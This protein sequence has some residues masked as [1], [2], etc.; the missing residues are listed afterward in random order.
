MVPVVVFGQMDPTQNQN[1]SPMNPQSP[2]NANVPLNQPGNPTQT[3]SQATPQNSMRD[4]LGA[5]G[6]TGQRMQDKRF[7]RSAAEAGV[8]DV[9]LAELAVQKSSSPAV[10]E[11]AQR[12][13]DDHT[14]INNDIADVADNVGV[15][16]PRKMSKRDQA[17]YEKLNGLSG[18]D[19]DT[20]Y[21]TYIAKEHWQ[22]LHTFHQEA[23]AA[24]MPGLEPEIVKA[25]HTMHEHLKLISETASQ[26]GITLPPRPQRP[27]KQMPAT[28]QQ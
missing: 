10:K 25:L 16:L 28:T 15:P 23:S 12:M 26:E 27:P 13:I 21:V 22:D 18:K 17:E 2:Q 20:E 7:I 1:P 24:E 5:P 14:A 8:G 9:K 4:S 6:V 3:G 19:F 11:L